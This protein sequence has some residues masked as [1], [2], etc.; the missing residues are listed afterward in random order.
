MERGEEINYRQEGEVR[1]GESTLSEDDLRQ[2][3]VA[4]FCLYPDVKQVEGGVKGISGK[5]GRRTFRK[6][7][8]RAE[9]SW[10]R[11]VNRTPSYRDLRRGF[12]T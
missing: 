11:A 12:I 9:R 7:I 1:E 5:T 3:N 6:K 8:H 2:K 10:G 4:I